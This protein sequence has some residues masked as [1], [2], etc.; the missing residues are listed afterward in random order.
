MTLCGGLP[1]REIGPL[2]DDASAALL[3]SRFPELASSVTR[4]L[5]EEAGGNPLA[6]LELPSELTA[7]QRASPA[8]KECAGC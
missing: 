8:R 5:L 3:R 4:R 6:L 7:P 1:E 2:D